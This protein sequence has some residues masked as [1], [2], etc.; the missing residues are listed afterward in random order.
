[1]Y[2]DQ[3]K[4]TLWLLVAVLISS[5]FLALTIAS[6][7]LARSTDT[8]SAESPTSL[9]SDNSFEEI[10]IYLADSADLATNS[11]PQEK[12]SRRTEVIRRLKATAATSQADLITYLENQKTAGEVETFE[13]LWIINAIL[14]T[15]RPDL[16]DQLA[17]QPG[18]VRVIPNETIPLLSP[19]ELAAETA[20]SEPTK[21]T[22][23]LQQIRAQHAWEAL[24][25][26]GTGVT[27]ATLDTGVDWRHPDLLNNYRGAFPNGSANHVYNWYDTVGGSA[28]PIDPN[29][30]GTHVTGTAV[31]SSYI[32]V[33][34]GAKWIA[35]RAL[36]A[37]G[38]GQLGDIHLAF[39]WLLAPGGN[40]AKAPDIVNN[41]WSGGPELLDFIPDVA[42]LKAAG[43]IPLFAA[44]NQGPD[45]G[46]VGAPAD[47]PDTIAIGAS[48]NFDAVTWFSGRGPSPLTNEIKPDFVAPGAHVLSSRPDGSYAYLNGTS[49]ATPHAVGAY[50]LLLSA[51]P[52]LTGD[53]I[54]EMIK[55][56][57]VPIDPPH[58]N[59]ETGWGRLDVYNALVGQV[60]T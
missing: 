15:V 52:N 29:G 13:P 32:G 39:Q 48:D 55:N 22:W 10:I 43:I 34:P 30:H 51:N 50:A 33:A 59:Q 2:N 56:S 19:Q 40:P 24:G 58:P 49:M 26:D 7:S 17:A 3:M 47:Y 5:I 45:P 9:P 57:A 1:M 31:G 8:P 27:I 21:L 41:S 25:I 16:V 38:G 12:I 54:T 4:R 18:V 28:V 14:A 35:V 11:L 6:P 42:A 44:G 37:N 46:S 23:G 60:T 36:D 20:A 53:Q